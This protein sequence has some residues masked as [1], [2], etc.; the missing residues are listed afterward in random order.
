MTQFMAFLALAVGPTFLHAQTNSNP[1]AYSEVVGYQ[2]ATLGAGKFKGVGISLLNPTVISGVVAS[3]SGYVLTLSNASN[4]GSKLESNNAT[5]YLEVNSPTNSPN[6]GDRLELNVA[7]TQADNN[8]TITLAAS[9]RNTANASSVSLA[10]GTGVV[11][12]KHVTLDQIRASITGTLV[13]D[14]N[15]SANADTIFVHNG[16]SFVPYWLASDLQSWLSND[17]P[18]DHRYDVIA[19]GQGLLFYKNGNSATF[20]SVGAV[21]SND[22]KQVLASGLQLNASGFPRAYS[23]VG[24]GGSIDRGWS[25]G[26]QIYVHNGI[27]FTTYTLSADGST[28]GY[29]DDNENPDPSNDV[30]IVDGGTAFLTNLKD[31]QID[32][33]ERPIK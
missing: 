12:R 29:W 9:P 11:V 19:P 4:L 26:D 8:G 7:S 18:D 21:R 14:D 24:I 33:E 10:L 30:Q 22:Y 1:P 17:D 28:Q 32:V 5:Y 16:N 25:G 2:K 6:M 13:G 20:T 15:T 27:G 3:K 23:P 31:A